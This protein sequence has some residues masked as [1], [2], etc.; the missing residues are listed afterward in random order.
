MAKSSKTTTKTATKRT[1]TKS[2]PVVEQSAKDIEIVEEPVVE[3]VEKPT[4]AEKK[5]TGL[6]VEVLPR[7]HC[8]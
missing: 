1:T 6:F 7:V 4:K 8:L 5:K 3:I 2:K